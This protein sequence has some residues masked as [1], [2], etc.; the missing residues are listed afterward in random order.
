[1]SKIDFKRQLKHLYNPSKKEFTVI[2]VP[3]M[4]FLMADG[5]GDPNTA[6]EYKDAVEAL[7][8]DIDRENGQIFDLSDLYDV[9][10]AGKATDGEAAT[11]QVLELELPGRTGWEYKK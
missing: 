4:Q 2:D 3:P 5:H 10:K 6:Q 1:M 11:E 9:H 8:A 7:Y